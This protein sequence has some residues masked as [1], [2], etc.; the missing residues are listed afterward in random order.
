MGTISKE[1]GTFT[2]NITA[3][4]S[5]DQ[6]VFSMIGYETLRIEISNIKENPLSVK[7]IPKVYE[8]KEV[9]VKAKRIKEPQK[10]GRYEITRTTTGQSGQDEFGIGCE[11]GVQIFNDNKKYKILDA[12]F[13]MRF[14]TVD[15][16]LFRVQIYSVKDG[17]P[18]ESLL[19]KETFVKSYKNDHWIICGL[20]E[21]DLTMDQDVIVT[22]EVVRFW[23]T[24][25][26]ENQFFFTHGSGYERG[27]A[28]SRQTS[29]DVWKVNQSPPVVLCLGVEEEK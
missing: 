22:Y 15:S 4:N 7:L 12:R 20:E 17:L 14:N 13:H 28:F 27:Q 10:L 26:S 3:A 19:N 5:N 23:P 2:I 8:L 11:W 29:H 25:G 18:H 6:L 24:K 9:I 16:A 21:H 1:D